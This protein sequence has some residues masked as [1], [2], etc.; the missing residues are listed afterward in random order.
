M[1][2]LKYTCPR[3]LRHFST[4]TTKNGDYQYI[5]RSRVPTMHFQKSLP[6]LPIPPLKKTC[7]RYLA[8]QRPLL[9]DKAFKHVT[10]Q[11]DIFSGGVGTKLDEM[12]RN[13][14]KNNKHTSYISKMWFDMYLSDR[15]PLPIN[16]NPFIVFH[17]DVRPE[18]NHQLIKAANVLVSSVRFMLS[19]RKNLLEPEVFHLDP[20]KSDTETFRRVTGFLPSAVSWYGAYAFNAY[21][22]DMSQYNGLFGSSRIPE[23]GKDRIVNDTKSKHILV[24]RRGYFYTFDVL[25]D[26]G[27]II[28]AHELLL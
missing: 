17:N 4:K 2:C 24:Q 3:N 8:A 26:E 6:R 27:E 19:L 23:I 1:L 21:P 16:Y 7:E 22:L 15:I 18:Y 14:D 13:T 12:L 9:G 25:D 5:Q 20:K 10:S 28:F 11:V